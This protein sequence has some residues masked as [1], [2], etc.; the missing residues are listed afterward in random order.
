MRY[1][2]IG[3]QI[4]ASAAALPSRHA[5]GARRGR[6][7]MDAAP[8][9]PYAADHGYVGSRPHDRYWQSRRCDADTLGMV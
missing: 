3:G 8:F 7:D 1:I 5:H 6:G 9:C 4:S 2:T